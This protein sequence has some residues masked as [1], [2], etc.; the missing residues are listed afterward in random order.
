MV[1]KY[2][3]SSAHKADHFRLVNQ[4]YKY[5]NMILTLSSMFYMR[6]S[7]VCEVRV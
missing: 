2:V 4:A 1:D 6:V 7:F 5:H 3:Q